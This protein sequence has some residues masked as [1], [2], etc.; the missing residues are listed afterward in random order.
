[1]HQMKRSAI[2]ESRVAVSRSSAG[3]LIA[4]NHGSGI[5]S[6]SNSI[7]EAFD[8]RGNAIHHNTFGG[9]TNIDLGA[10]GITPND[11]GDADLGV[12]L[13][14]NKPELLSVSESGDQA[15][16]RYRVD[17]LPAHASYPLRIDFYVGEAE[18]SGSWLA[19]DSYPASA[20]GLMRQ[21]TF[22]LPP[23]IR[24]FPLTATASSANHISELAPVYDT[25]FR[26]EFEAAL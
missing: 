16:V 25:L 8:S 11:P 17:S 18:G 23:G 3:N 2:G 9:A 19:Q 12:N 21:F 7:G 10:F 22:T 20:A 24:A 6:G 14:Q 26:D 5:T 15:T 4:F 13:Q 1:M